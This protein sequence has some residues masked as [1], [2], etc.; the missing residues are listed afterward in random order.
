MTNLNN[1]KCSSHL[2]ANN[3]VVPD[4]VDW[5]SKG[6]VTKVKDQVIVRI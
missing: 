2:S 5:R 4:S 1:T 6:Y 3:I